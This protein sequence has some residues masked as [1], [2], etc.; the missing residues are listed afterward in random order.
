PNTSGSA[1]GTASF[2]SDH[3]DPT[4][5][6]GTF[7]IVG[8]STGTSTANPP[9][10]VTEAAAWQVNPG[11][12]QPA[13]IALGFLNTQTTGTFFSQAN[14]QTEAWMVVLATPEPGT[15]SLVGVCA[16]SMLKRPRRR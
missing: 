3:S 16:L 4:I 13:P 2:M 10:N 11:N 5:G 6:A 8:S 15:L 9:T 12:T 14:G 1:T 7:T